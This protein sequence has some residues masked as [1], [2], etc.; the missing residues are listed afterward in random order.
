MGTVNTSITSQVSSDYLEYSLAS[1]SRSIPDLYDGLIPSR[2]RL[3]QTMYE[4]G[5][6]PSRPYVKCAR[7][8]GLTSAYYHP[9]GSA[10]GS[11]ISMATPW[12]NNVSWV[13]CHGNI[14]SSV[15]GPAAERYV[16]NR[17]RQ[18]ALD[19]L[20]QDKGTWETKPNYDN[21]REEAVRFNSS[22]PAV[23]L[24]GDTGISVGY[25]TKL[26]PH[27]LLSIVEAVKLI[28]KPAKDKAYLSN[29][30]K[31]RELL[32]PDFPT[33]PEIVKDDQLEQYK[34]SGSGSIRCRAKVTEGVQK[35]EGRAKDRVTLTFTHLPP[36]VNP[37]KVGDQIKDGLEKG[38][39]EGVAEVNDLSD[40]GGDCIEIVGKPGVNVNKLKTQI[41]SFTDLDT[42]YSAKTLVMRDLKPVDIS[43]VEVVKDWVDWRLG[44]LKV[45][46]EEELTRRKERSEIVEGLIKAVDKLDL[47]IKRIRSSEDKAEAKASL[48]KKPL[49]FTS[50][51]A[52]AILEMRLRQLTNLDQSELT[53]EFEK[54]RDRVSELTL[55][56]D[57]S[58]SG[59]AARKVFMTKEVTELGK[60]FGQPRRSPLVDGVP[61]VKEVARGGAKPTMSKP[62]FVKIDMKRGVV[63][64]AKGPRGS[65]VLDPKDKLILMTQ[66]GMLKKVPATY[67]GTV[68]NSYSTVKLAKKEAEVLERKFIVV[69]E[70]DG[71]LKGMV[72][73]GEDLCKTTSSGKRWLPDGSNLRYFG[74]GPYEISWVSPRKKPQKIDL[75]LKP[76]KPGGK[77]IKLANLSEVK[78]EV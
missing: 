21:S 15:D 6:L 71:Q 59:D 47:I 7:T 45:K 50:K 27:N 55:L 39:I 41:F 2:R 19:I 1:L 18:E 36:G 64:Q 49:S 8:T 48:M 61:E 11:L 68:S 57:I 42:K 33:G 28:C 62:R 70:L 67:K 66:D 65:M 52:E 72:L 40:L 26:A 56:V 5:F 35:R 63:E 76:G 51:Q 22:L 34:R 58:C 10:Y 3:L 73:Q 32:V 43:P 24:N 37:E 23:L 9:H 53:L 31:A 75:T 17:L 29:L 69:F 77:G 13:D 12:T 16:E 46:F 38:R 25:S 14:G 30:D 74:E 20:L 78:S 60:K 4:E 44:R 54:L